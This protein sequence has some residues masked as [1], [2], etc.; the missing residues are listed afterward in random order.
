MPGG[1]VTSEAELFHSQNNKAML[2]SA[3]QETG[4]FQGLDP[5]QTRR[6]MASINTRV[7]EVG[8]SGAG[9]TRSGMNKR[10]LGLVM[11]DI[12]SLKE[13]TVA[14][15]SGQGVQRAFAQKETAIRRMSEG[16]RPRDLDFS[17][18]T[19]KP[20][21]SAMDRAVQEALGS[22]SSQ[23]ESALTGYASSIKT[24]ESW[25]GRARDPSPQVRQL[26][27]G[28]TL[29]A[30]AVGAIPVPKEK[31]VRFEEDAASKFLSSI[32]KTD[33]Q[34]APVLR[35]IDRIARS[36]APIPGLLR[37][38]VERLEALE[39]SREPSATPKSPDPVDAPPPSPEPLSVGGIEDLGGEWSPLER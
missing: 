22:R 3:L 5:G 24:A 1:G 29:D 36:I 9:T 6:V 34:D 32:K 27:I 10:V 12:T 21:G 16:E 35:A 17:E 20:M 14:P 11:G 18:P 19:D 2:W 33:G 30:D 26:K 37:D 39:K 38:V 15:E 13:E 8:A 28:E 23:M 25:I 4:S 7:M 31:Q